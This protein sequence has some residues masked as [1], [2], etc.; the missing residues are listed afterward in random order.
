MT[1]LTVLTPPAEDPVTLDAVKAFLRIGDA[2]EDGLA[3]DLIG[4]ARARLERVA[5]LAL[6]DQSIRFIWRDWSATSHGGARLPV[7]PVRQLI[8]VRFVDEEAGTTEV[9]DQFQIVCDRLVLRPWNALPSVPP[10]GHVEIDLRVGFGAAAD[11][12]D[13]LSE[14]L[15][16]L[17]GAMYSTRTPG[18]FDLSAAGGLPQNVQAILDARKEVRL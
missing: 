15:L 3:A 14:A 1:Q 6:V 17:I 18:A 7:S 2:S 8:A 9:T 16:R 13:D 5:G 10:G 12:P 11:V 4:A